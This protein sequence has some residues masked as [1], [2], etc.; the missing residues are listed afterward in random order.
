[1]G[2]A[3]RALDG[4]GLDSGSPEG[5]LNDCVKMYEE[6]E[7]RLARL[8]ERDIEWSHD[9]ALTWFSAALTSHVTCLD[10]LAENGLSF[11]AQRAQNLTSVIREGLAV[12][13]AQGKLGGK[14]KGIC[15]TLHKIIYTKR[16]YYIY[17]GLCVIRYILKILVILIKYSTPCNYVH[18][19]ILVVFI[20]KILI[21]YI[22]TMQ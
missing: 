11:E 1:M 20:R 19:K 22:Y 17:Q 7:S 6:A 10:G 4:S 21:M 13:R 8:V 18:L 2:S 14:R 5:C 15:F 16:K 12:Y 3:F 9:D